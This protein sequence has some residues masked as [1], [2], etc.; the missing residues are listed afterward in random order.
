[1]KEIFK[2]LLKFIFAN[3]K[4]DEKLAET[5]EIA[6]EEITK[7]DQKFDDFKADL[8][9]VPIEE[10]E[11]PTEEAEVPTEEQ[12]SEPLEAEAPQ[13]VSETTEQNV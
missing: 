1:M 4:L 6:K 9:R 8:E 12:S 2:T 13:E 10:V 3:T 11:V 5:L 7:L